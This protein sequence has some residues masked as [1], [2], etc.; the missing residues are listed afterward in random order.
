MTLPRCAGIYIQT[1]GPTTFHLT[2]MDDSPY[3][4]C[5]GNTRASGPSSPTTSPCCSVPARPCANAHALA[6]TN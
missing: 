6:D 5:N 4:P 1:F 2:Q 3:T